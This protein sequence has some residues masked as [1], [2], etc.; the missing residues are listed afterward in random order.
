VAPYGLWWKDGKR[1]QYWPEAGNQIE[2]F[3][4]WDQR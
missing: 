4:P 2:W 3:V 1:V